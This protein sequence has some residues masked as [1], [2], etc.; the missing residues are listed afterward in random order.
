MRRLSP[1]ERLRLRHFA[2]K[3]WRRRR[4]RALRRALWVQEQAA[5]RQL[6]APV[7]RTVDG[8]FEILLPEVFS[9]RQ[10]YE[11]VAGFFHKVREEVL[12]PPAY[13]RALGRYRVGL[14]FRPV[15]ELG[16]SAALILAAELDRWQR[17]TGR[18]LNATELE[19]W[20]PEVRRQFMDLGLFD[21]LRTPNVVSESPGTESGV[22][23]LRFVRGEGSDGTAAQSFQGGLEA[24][25]GPISAP[26]YLYDGITE[27]MTNVRHH[28]YPR[29]H[30]RIPPLRGAWWMTG[31]YSPTT[32]RMQAMVFDQGVGIPE[33][34]PR[35]TRWE[36]I[37]GY[38]NEFK[39]FVNDDAAMIYAAMQVSRSSV[40][41][42]GRGNGLDNIRQF[43]DNS[44]AGRLRIL[45]GRGE[46][47]YVKGEGFRWVSHRAPLGGT[48]IE[49]E[50][51]R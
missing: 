24:I 6:P 7:V 13:H 1:T 43:I 5:L 49:W 33:T 46:V 21:L 20:Y 32:G 23:L 41:I 17:R 27:A 34:L 8:F 50:V 31:S 51:W 42:E 19:A 45:S 38:M 48:L 35:C 12:K 16:P 22:R 14:D 40:P 9:L 44:D 26:N 2:L 39:F 10:N 29:R 36:R 18:Q 30:Y 3:R 37:R 15:R 4:R 28:A 25:A 47:A 11:E